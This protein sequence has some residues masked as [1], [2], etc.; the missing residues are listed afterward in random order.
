[1][2][3]VGFTFV[4]NSFSYAYGRKKARMFTV[5]LLLLTADELGAV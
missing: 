5:T 1:M 3:L 4:L 2:I